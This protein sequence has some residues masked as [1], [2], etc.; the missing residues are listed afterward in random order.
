MDLN[1]VLYFSLPN[2]DPKYT[3]GIAV[4]KICVHL[5]SSTNVRAGHGIETNRHF[6]LNIKRV[7]NLLLSYRVHLHELRAFAKNCGAK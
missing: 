6:L 3:I 2:D 1:F 7:A 4:A 5:A